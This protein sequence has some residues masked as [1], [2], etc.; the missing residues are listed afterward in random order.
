MRKL[1]SRS[2]SGRTD[3]A[4]RSGKFTLT[5]LSFEE[6][7]PVKYPKAKWPIANVYETSWYIADTKG[8][9]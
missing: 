8:T 3:A 4:S 5:L 1:N 2:T 6:P 7:F 9:Y